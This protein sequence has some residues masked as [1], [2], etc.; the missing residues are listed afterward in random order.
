MITALDF[1]MSNEGGRPT[2]RASDLLEPWL[3]NGKVAGDKLELA[4]AESCSR[5]RMGLAEPALR[6]AAQ[7]SCQRDVQ[8]IVAT[9]V[10]NAGCLV[11]GTQLVNHDASEWVAR[12][13]YR[14][15]VSAVRPHWAHLS[16][17]S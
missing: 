2:N 8:I 14:G 6:V 7:L 10:C 15:M 17:T 16:R 5:S 11:F 13:G 12:E 9:D 3:V 1:E 4:V